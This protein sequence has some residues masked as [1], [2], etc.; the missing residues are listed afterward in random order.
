MK[1]ETWLSWGSVLQEPPFRNPKLLPLSPARSKWLISPP[2]SPSYVN[3]TQP[4]A[5]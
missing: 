2:V 3:G 1:P 4:S 5:W